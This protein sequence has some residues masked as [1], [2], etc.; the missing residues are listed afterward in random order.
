MWVLNVGGGGIGRGGVGWDGVGRGGTAWDGAGWDGMGWEV[1]GPGC[2][3]S[4]G[5]DSDL[6]TSGGSM[7]T[8][9]RLGRFVGIG[10]G[11]GGN[12]VGAPQC[13]GREGARGSDEALNTSGG[14]CVGG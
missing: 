10:I 6:H 3:G 2:D 5:S 4:W 9:T 8:D 1:R 7:S 14:R 11:D 13:A 12:C